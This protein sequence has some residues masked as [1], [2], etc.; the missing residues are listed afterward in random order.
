[1]YAITGKRAEAMEVLHHI[2]AKSKNRYVTPYAA[3]L[4][5]LGVSDKDKTITLLN[6]CVAERTNWLVWLLKDPRW[7]PMRADPRFQEIV[8][9]VGFPADAQARQPKV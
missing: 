7:D 8:R 4:I 2:E 5:Y 9:K 3:T 6:Q 1:M